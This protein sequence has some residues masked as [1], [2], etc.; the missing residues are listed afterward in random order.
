[1]TYLGHQG[2]LTS[3][4]NLTL[5]FQGH[6]LYVCPLTMANVAETTTRARVNP[7]PARPSPT[8]L[9]TAEGEG[10]GGVAA[11]MLSR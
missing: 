8:S 4:Q 6:Q 1:M 2:T 7:H 5:T 9:S 3:G 10:G 11:P